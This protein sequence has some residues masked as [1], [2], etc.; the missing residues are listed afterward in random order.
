MTRNSA[1]VLIA[2]L[3]TLVASHVRA[4]TRVTVHDFHGPS[5]ARI[6]ADVVNLLERQS[7]V[8]LVSKGQIE[9]AARKLGVDRLSL[10]GRQALARELQ[11]SAWMTGQVQRRNGKLRLTVE[12]YDGAQHT[13]I[14]R[15]QLVGSTAAR[16]SAAIKDRL[17]QQSGSVIMDA[18]APAAE[19]KSSTTVSPEIVVSQAEADSFRDK[20]DSE[21][22]S[23]TGLGEVLRAFVG[24]GSP[25][26]SLAY[27]EPVTSSLGDYQLSGAAMADINVAFHPARLATDSW[28]AWFGLDARAQVT[29][30]SPTLDRN[31]NQFKSRYDAFHVGMRAR[32]PLGHHYVSA[33]SGY[34]MNR[35]AISAQETGV[36]TP[37]PS[38]DYRSIRSGLGVELAL[39]D[40]LLLGLDAAW[41]RLLSV[42]DIGKWFPRASA[43]GVEFAMLASY[44]MTEAT[45]LRATAAYQRTFFDF[46]SRPG[47]KNVAGGATD[48]Y[49]ALSLGMG[50][51]L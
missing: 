46:N 14:G 38:V 28:P 15:A 1:I 50:V 37:T 21:H 2:A 6:R 26:R 48:Q 16:L 17:W 9:G 11:L 33:F 19:S 40:S 43:G 44:R 27:R 3:F 24:I 47:D 39:S 7:G 8:T 31:G 25:Y 35:L 30:S 5:A 18:A 4:D 20:V 51:S 49:L 36:R 23:H 22:A 13:R 32:V 42:G 34:G 29:L 45:F 10:D 41:L 12:V